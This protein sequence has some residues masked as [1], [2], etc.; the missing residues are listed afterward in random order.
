MKSRLTTRQ[1]LANGEG[2]SNEKNQIHEK[3]NRVKTL[4]R[5][6]NPRFFKI[7]ILGFDI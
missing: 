6:I 7:A 4:S 2:K 3:I 5:S 1:P